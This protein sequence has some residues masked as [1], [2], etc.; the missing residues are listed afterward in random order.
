MRMNIGTTRQIVIQAL[1]QIEKA[2]AEVRQLNNILQM[3]ERIKVNSDTGK[4][5][6]F[7]VEDPLVL[8]LLLPGEVVFNTAMT[9]LPGKPY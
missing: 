2:V 6:R 3:E 7:T 1:E 4:T 9:R 5:E 8:R